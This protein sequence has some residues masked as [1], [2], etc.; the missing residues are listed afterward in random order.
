MRSAGTTPVNLS[1][2]LSYMSSDEKRRRIWKQALI[3]PAALRRSSIPTAVPPSVGHCR[4]PTGLLHP[5]TNRWPQEISRGE[6][7]RAAI[8]KKNPVMTGLFLKTPLCFAP[9]RLLVWP[10]RRGRQPRAALRQLRCLCHSLSGGQCHAGSLE[11][12]AGLW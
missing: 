2:P 6:N 12:A 3:R 1:S 7:D 5:A 9:Q 8:K 10:V 4:T 11:G